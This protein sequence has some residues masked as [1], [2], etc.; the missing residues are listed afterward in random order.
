LD[1]WDAMVPIQWRWKT[2]TRTPIFACWASCSICSVYVVLNVVCICTMYNSKKWRD[3]ACVEAVWGP[4]KCWCF[5]EVNDYTIQL[6]PMNWLYIYILY[7]YMSVHHAMKFT[8]STGGG[9]TAMCLP[10]AVNL[11]DLDRMISPWVLRLQSPASAILFSDRSLKLDLRVSPEGVPLK[12][13]FFICIQPVV[14]PLFYL[15]DEFVKVRHFA[16]TENVL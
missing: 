11:S 15:V 6:I 14:S 10:F 4:L 13:G 12:I 7:T 16:A 5:I 1:D 3:V 9:S 2:P 8:H